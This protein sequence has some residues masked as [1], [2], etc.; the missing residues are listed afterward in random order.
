EVVI[1]VDARLHQLGLDLGQGTEPIAKPLG[2]LED[3]TA[4]TVATLGE[5]VQ[6]RPERAEGRVELIL[7]LLA[8]LLE[9]GTGDPLAGGGGAA[10]G[11]PGRG[12]ARGGRPP[13]GGPRRGAEPPV[14]ARDRPARGTTEDRSRARRSAG[15]ARPVGSSPSTR[16]AR[17]PSH[18][19][20]W[21]PVL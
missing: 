9:A 4:G 3:A 13:S 7:D 21:G 18:C 6:M 8:Q 14:A 17:A 11:A 20:D 15:V 16:A 1:A 19:P 5:L 12:G 10:A 2:L